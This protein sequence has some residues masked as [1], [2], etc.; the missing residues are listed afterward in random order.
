VQTG[1][2]DGLFM[3]FQ[4]EQR[5][6]YLEYC[7][8]PLAQQNVV[9]L[10]K[11]DSPLNS[12]TDMAAVEALRLGTINQISYGPTLDRLIRAGAF[13]KIESS[14]NFQEAMRKFQASRFDVLLTS[15]YGAQYYFSEQLRQGRLRILPE[16][17][18]QVPGF[19][20]L[21]KRPGSRHLCQQFDGTL[22]EMK[23]DGSYRRLQARYLH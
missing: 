17:S 22:A 15:A 7:H 11:R 8:E 9:F 4:N 13:R 1:K 10:V 14:N 21:A 2:V 12:P 23:K 19:L 20:T 5:Q 18:Q 16:L 3:V 6:Q